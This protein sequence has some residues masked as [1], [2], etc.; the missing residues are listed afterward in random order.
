[1]KPT[2]KDIDRII[3]LL[4][5]ILMIVM[6]ALYF[7]EKESFFALCR[8]Y[9]NLY[10]AQSVSDGTYCQCV[11]ALSKTPKLIPINVSFPIS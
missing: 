1:M 10:E 7:N 11:R 8:N 9:C 4:V 2:V 5:S 6:T 3:L